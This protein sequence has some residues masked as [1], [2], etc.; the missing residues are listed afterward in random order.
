[1]EEMENERVAAELSSTTSGNPDSEQALMTSESLTESSASGGRVGDESLEFSGELLGAEGGEA[2]GSMNRNESERSFQM[3]SSD[4]DSQSDEEEARM[5]AQIRSAIEKD[6]M[7]DL[8]GDNGDPENCDIVVRSSEDEESIAEE[9]GE[10]T[11]ALISNKCVDDVA[12]QEDND[13]CSC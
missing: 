4:L 1:M 11:A 12:D 8:A 5:V 3:N 9:E 2:I 13:S 10:H 7:S 6:I